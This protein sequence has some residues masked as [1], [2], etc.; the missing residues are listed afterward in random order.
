MLTGEEDFQVC[1]NQIKSMDQK[2]H[3]PPPIITHQAYPHLLH[4]TNEP[5][6][7]TEVD[8]DLSPI[9]TYLRSFASNEE[10][11]PEELTQNLC[12]FLGMCAFL[13]PSDIERINLDNCRMDDEFI[14]LHILRPKETSAGI[15][16]TKSVILRAHSLDR[17]IC[18]VQTFKDYV[19]RIAHNKI[20]VPHPTMASLRYS[21]LVRQ[22]KSPELHM[23][24]QRI[25]KYI[26]AIMSRAK[27][28]PGHRLPKACAA[29]PTHAAKNGV[30]VDDIV[31]Q[32]LVFPP[33]VRQLLPLVKQD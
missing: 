27:V 32:E 10:M 29:G 17:Q 18:P 28:P 5:D 9:V 7:S 21:P 24:A 3:K 26:A 8:L 20:S 31:A 25:S 4:H 33:D 6:T 23:E 16:K 11:S 13:R 19:R 15:H 1:Q 14:S 12:W 22:V 30:S 2:Y